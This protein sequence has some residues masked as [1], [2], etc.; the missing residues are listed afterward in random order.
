MTTTT[1]A[2]FFESIR[3]REAAMETLDAVLIALEKAKQFE[4]HAVIIEE[5][6][7]IMERFPL[8]NVDVPKVEAAP[9][10]LREQAA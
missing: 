3:A 7:A 5:Y 9:A 10:L 2:Q 8:T 1:A 4:A 6:A